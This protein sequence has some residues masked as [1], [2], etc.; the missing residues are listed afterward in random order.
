M[1][2]EKQKKKLYIGRGL[3]ITIPE[4][5]IKYGEPSSSSVL[6]ISF[7]RLMASLLLAISRQMI[8]R[9]RLEGFLS[10]NKLQ[11]TKITRMLVQEVA[12]YVTS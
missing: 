10:L 4:P 9:N 11:Y 5:K 6:T 1:W 2:K 3:L 7:M 8:G 12:E